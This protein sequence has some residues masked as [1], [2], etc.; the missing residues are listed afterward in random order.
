LCYINSER[1]KLNGFESLRIDS[2]RPDQLRDIKFTTN[3]LEHPYS[4]VLVEFGKTKVVCAVSVDEVVPKWM[5]KPE[6]RNNIHGWI[7]SEYRMLPFSSGQGRMQR[8]GTE[9]NLAGRTHEIQRLIGRSLRSVIDLKKL[10][11]RTIWIDCDV[12]QADG[13]TRTAAV[14]GGFVALAIALIR[15]QNDGKILKPF[16]LT[17]VAAVSVGIRSG[18]TMLDLCYEEDSSAQVDMNVVMTESGEFIEI[19]GTAEHEPFRREQYNQMI[20]LA[21]K[22]IHDIIKIQK[23]AVREGL[24][25]PKNSSGGA[26]PA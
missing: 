3:Y 24:Q 16:E 7:T 26:H 23:N 20:D 10:G 6:N 4:S 15:L 5:M 18:M 1:H 12:L 17:Y 22:G 9:A 25:A 13:G 14:S 11:Q 19:Q 8:E 2:R 21:E